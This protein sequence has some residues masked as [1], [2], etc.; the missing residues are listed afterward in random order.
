MKK[1]IQKIFNLQGYKVLKIDSDHVKP[2]NFFFPE[3]SEFDLNF[4]KNLL[5]VIS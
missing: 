4:Y 1:I 2:N 3:A 5:K